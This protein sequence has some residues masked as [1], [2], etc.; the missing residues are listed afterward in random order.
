[1]SHVTHVN[2]SF[3]R[4]NES[5]M[6][7][8]ARMQARCH[9]A[10]RRSAIQSCERDSR[11]LV[12]HV[13]EFFCTHEWVMTHIHEWVMNVSWTS[14][15]ARM[16]AWCH[17]AARRHAIRSRPSSRSGLATLLIKCAPRKAA[18]LL[19]R[20]CVCVCRFLSLCLSLSLPTPTTSPVVTMGRLPTS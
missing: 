3:T 5:W 13:T 8:V 4:M 2:E 7:H 9:V 16:Q 12:T 1:M 20:V 19:L 17:G 15:V 18:R 10:A 6:S 14:H 11:N